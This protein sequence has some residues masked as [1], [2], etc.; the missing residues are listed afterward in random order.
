MQTR[1]VKFHCMTINSTCFEKSLTNDQ[2]EAH[3]KR[4]CMVK[5]GYFMASQTVTLF[6][7]PHTNIFL[8][9]SYTNTHTPFTETEKWTQN[10]I[11]AATR[12]FVPRLMLAELVNLPFNLCA[13]KFAEMCS[14]RRTLCNK[15]VDE[16]D[17]TDTSKRTDP[18]RWPKTRL[19]LLHYHMV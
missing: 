5:K 6:E 3:F 2:G 9:P 4:T 1:S 16:T 14:A 19:I 7:H 12:G 17:S 11:H 15:R 18:H 10:T 13:W 8:F